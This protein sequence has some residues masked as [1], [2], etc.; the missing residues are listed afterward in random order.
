MFDVCIWSYYSFFPVCYPCFGTLC[1]CWCR[2]LRRSLMQCFLHAISEY[3][4]P[5]LQVPISSSPQ[6]SGSTDTVKRIYYKLCGTSKKCCASHFVVAVEHG[7][8]GKLNMRDWMWTVVQRRTCATYELF[9][10]R[11]DNCKET[12]TMKTRGGE[13]LCAR[14]FPLRLPAKTELYQL[15]RFPNH[16]FFT[17]HWEM[18]QRGSAQLFSAVPE[19]S[20]WFAAHLFRDSA[21]GTL[22]LMR[23]E[24]LP[25][26]KKRKCETKL[27]DI[28]WERRHQYTYEWLQKTYEKKSLQPC[29]VP[30]E[31]SLHAN[32]LTAFC[33]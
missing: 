4:F 1:M 2:E 10:K 3:V 30:L 29:G 25:T 6:R 19:N 5:S 17:V 16:T 21:L 11:N 8:H 31:T 18:S 23:D 20:R 28:C 7:K 15:Q 32:K 14:I 22:S 12:S 13:I 27:T 33:C 26:I 24:Q 9:R